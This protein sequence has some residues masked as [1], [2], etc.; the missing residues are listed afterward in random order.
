MPKPEL[1]FFDVGPL[2]WRPVAGW[3]GVYEKTLSQDEK[4]GDHTRLLRFEPGVVTTET[5]THDFWE[6]VW[7]VQGGLIDVAKKQTFTEGMYACRPPG[8]K[9][10][11]Y[12]VPIGC[13][14]FEVRY[15]PK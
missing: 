6:E 14:T 5:L 2:P 4:T 1:E 7:I 9:H 15:Y 10:G 11:P 8:M 13:V 12:Q 3:P